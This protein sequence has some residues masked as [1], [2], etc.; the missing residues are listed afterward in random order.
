[1]R[2]TNVL[3]ACTRRTIRRAQ[4]HFFSA[5]GWR[6][7]HPTTSEFLEGE[8]E[9]DDDDDDDGAYTA[10]KATMN[11]WWPLVLSDGVR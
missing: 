3:R 11:E 9:I 5:S 6:A 8:T 1:M 10:K 7:K 4:T 2:F